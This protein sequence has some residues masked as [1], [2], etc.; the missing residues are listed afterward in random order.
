MMVCSTSL[1]HMY[2]PI[3]FFCTYRSLSLIF[4]TKSNHFSF[5]YV[6]I[7]HKIDR[8]ESADENEDETEDQDERNG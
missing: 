5:F 2:R 6:D 1:K 8:K 4:W 3:S 7:V